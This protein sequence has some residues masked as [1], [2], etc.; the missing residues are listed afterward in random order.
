MSVLAINTSWLEQHMLPCGM[1]RLFLIDCPGCGL[2]RS[3]LSLLKGD[4][5]ASWDAYPPTAFVLATLLT[6]ILHLVFSLRHGA[7]LLKVF[8]IMTISAITL[9]YIYKILNHQLL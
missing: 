8:F 3:V 1:K 5:A 6:L 7:L 2:Q 9:N 4:F